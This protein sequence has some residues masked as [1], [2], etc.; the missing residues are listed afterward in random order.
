MCDPT[1]LPP[2]PPTGR[3]PLPLSRRRREMSSNKEQRS[4][5]FVVLFA[6]ITILIL[7]SSNSA[8]EVFH[9]GSLRGRTRRPVN[10]KKWSITDAYVP[11]LGNKTLPSRCHQCVIVTSSSH[12]LGTK[13][14][15]EIERAE[16][17]I[18]MNDA[19]TTGYSADVGNKTTFRVVAHS[20]VFRVLRRPQEFVNRTPETVFIFWG[21]PNKMQKPQGSLVR[22]IQRAGLVFPNMEAYAVSPGRMRQF[23]DLFR[24]E[25]GKDREK[26]HSWLSTGWFTMVIA[27]ELCD[28]VHVYGMVPPDYCSGPVCSACPTTTMNP[29]GQMSVSPTSRMSTAAK[30]TTTA[31]S[32]R[33]GSSHP[34]PSCMESPSPTPPGPRLPCLW[35]S[36]R[37]HRRVLSPPSHSTKGHLLAN[38]G[39]PECLLA[40]QGLVSSSQG[41]GVSLDQSGI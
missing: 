40:N 33:R 30:A 34:G 27:V 13:L 12:L 28:H 6:L 41:L 22:V 20:S 31:S 5:V 15:P 17:T 36:H 37:G 25:T 35:T 1:S 39:W 8:N 10:L 32:P 23:D 7:Y 16:C 29:R 14:G 21:P 11:I 9:Y 2:G 19:P 26:S 3:W 38:Q 4:A 24:G 18:R